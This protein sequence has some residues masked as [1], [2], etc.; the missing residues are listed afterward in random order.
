MVVRGRLGVSHHDILEFLPDKVRRAV[1]KTTTMDFWRADFGLFKTWVGRVP[2]EAVLKDKGLQEGWA[3]FKKEV[4]KAQEQ[5]V[6][7]GTRQ[8]RGEDDQPG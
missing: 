1:R 5:A 7:I 6:S 2:W 8:T 4:W 3:F